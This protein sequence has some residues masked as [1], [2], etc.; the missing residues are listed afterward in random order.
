MSK[1]ILAIMML[2]AAA[3]VTSC[4]DKKKENETAAQAMPAKK[5]GPVREQRR[6]SCDTVTWRGMKTIIMIERNADEGGDIVSDETGTKYCDNE[7]HLNITCGGNEVV[8]R[9]LHKSDFKPYMDA[10]LYNKYVLEGLVFDTIKDGNLIL[11][12]SVANPSQED[13]Y[14]PFKITVTPGGGFTVTRDN[15]LDTSSPEDAEGDEE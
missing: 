6:Q 13:E 12:A 5:Q 4:G 1:F 11:A 14:M 9:T 8:N 3:L 7:M 10:G 15:E 2:M